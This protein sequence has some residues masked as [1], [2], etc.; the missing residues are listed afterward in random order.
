MATCDEIV[1]GK[2]RAVDRRVEI[3]LEEE[4]EDEWKE[5]RWK[6]KEREDR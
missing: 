2:W 3:V 4:K 5:G 6:R 1:Y